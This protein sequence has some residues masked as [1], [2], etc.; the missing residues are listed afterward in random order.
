MFRIIICIFIS[1]VIFCENEIV[2]PETE[3][4]GWQFGDIMTYIAYIGIACAG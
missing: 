1:P 3:A 2:S 4:Y